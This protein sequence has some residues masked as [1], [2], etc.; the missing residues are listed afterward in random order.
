MDRVTPKIRCTHREAGH[1]IRVASFPMGATDLGQ[2]YAMNGMQRNYNILTSA[3]ALSEK[4]VAQVVSKMI[5]YAPP[6]RLIISIAY[7]DFCSIEP[8][9]NIPSAKDIL[10]G[11]ENRFLSS[12]AVGSFKDLHSVLEQVQ[13]VFEELECPNNES[14]DQQLEQRCLSLCYDSQVAC[15][16]IAEWSFDAMKNHKFALEMLMKDRP[17]DVFVH[18]KNTYQIVVDMV[19]CSDKLELKWSQ[20]VTAYDGALETETAET[21]IARAMKLYWGV[22]KAH[23]HH[24]RND[25]IMTLVQGVGSEFA[26]LIHTME[27]ELVDSA[28]SSWYAW[29]AFGHFNAEGAKVFRTNQAYPMMSSSTAITPAQIN[30]L[31]EI[32]DIATFCLATRKVL[33]IMQ[34]RNDRKRIRLEEEQHRLDEK[35]RDTSEAHHRASSKLQEK[36]SERRVQEQELACRT[37][38]M[39]SLRSQIHQENEEVARLHR[40]IRQQEERQCNGLLGIVPIVG[41]VNAIVKNDAKLAIPGYASID[42]LVSAIRGDL[43]NAQ[44]C[45]ERTQ[46][47]VGHLQEKAEQSHRLVAETQCEIDRLVDDMSRFQSKIDKYDCSIR[48]TGQELCT[49]NEFRGQVLR[50]QSRYQ[51]L[52]DDMDLLL[53]LDD[54]STKDQCVEALRCLSLTV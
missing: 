51:F 46:G 47:T 2:P 32:Q 49:V 13:L 11:V 42:A 54:I 15:S 17:D 44:K 38:E 30:Q 28:T 21:K 19:C 24:R 50:L 23:C 37:S 9:L 26:G 4:Q 7:P 39:D 27:D 6:T 20:L 16:D 53:E 22:V 18:L 35:L 1:T 41:I 3:F 52:R 45:Q 8:I 5:P 29:V 10:N 48:S 34:E 33:N 31:A 25:F 14:F 43:T 40:E 12:G 36:E